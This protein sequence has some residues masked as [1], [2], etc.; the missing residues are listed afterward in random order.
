MSTPFI[1]KK[2]KYNIPLTRTLSRDDYCKIYPNAIQ[3]N[4]NNEI[5]VITGSNI[6]IVDLKLLFA[7]DPLRPPSPEDTLDLDLSTFYCV[8]N[9]H[10][11]T[12]DEKTNNNDNDNNTCLNFNL[13]PTIS[14]PTFKNARWCHRPPSWFMYHGILAAIQSNYIVTLYTRLLDDAQ[15]RHFRLTHSKISHPNCISWFDEPFYSDNNRNIQYIMIG[16]T[17][18][19]CILL[20]LT[21]KYDQISCIDVD[22]VSE[23]TCL[24]NASD[25]AITAINTIKFYGQ[26]FVAVGIYSGCVQIWINND[27][28][29][30]DF[31]RV[32]VID[33]KS[34]GGISCMKWFRAFDNKSNGIY[35]CIA[36]CRQIIILYISRHYSSFDW[37][38]DKTASYYPRMAI[39]AIDF[40]H[41]EDKYIILSSSYDGNIYAWLLPKGNP[42][43]KFTEQMKQVIGNDLYNKL[44]NDVYDKLII[45]EINNNTEMKDDK[46]I[47]GSLGIQCDP[48]CLLVS[49]I[50][51]EDSKIN[52]HIYPVSMNNQIIHDLLLQHHFLSRTYLQPISVTLV[53]RCLQTY[54]VEMMEQFIQYYKSQFKKWFESSDKLEIN[55]ILNHENDLRYSLLMIRY[56]FSMIANPPKWFRNH[57]QYII[58][59]LLQIHCWK[60][61]HQFVCSHNNQNVDSE[62]DYI[63]IYLM[64]Y[65]NVTPHLK[66]EDNQVTPVFNYLHQQILEKLTSIFSLLKDNNCTQKCI[67]L[68][69]NLFADEDNESNNEQNCTIN[70]K[71]MDRCPQCN[72]VTTVSMHNGYCGSQRDQHLIWRCTVTFKIIIDDNQLHCSLCEG[73]N[74]DNDID[75]MTHY[76]NHCLPF[77]CPICIIP[78]TKFI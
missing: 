74:N 15:W 4:T 63:C 5:A 53:M 1:M 57:I 10:Q 66:Q 44:N 17:H 28:D 60:T 41:I 51:H 42:I 70:F 25:V 35:C 47:Y 9:T 29:L 73:D 38:N 78:L 14:T 67:F 36:A 50:T 21:F 54:Y 26:Y 27:E 16:T 37:M 20:K 39:S 2:H 64:F 6:D 69:D 48:N 11:S 49:C 32:R 18:A 46:I 58:H 72:S 71:A 59:T 8:S 55:D 76:F 61:M 62:R 52:L 56:F 68:Q 24:S 7:G 19:S 34:T 23:I 13:I 65:W 3:W 33:L 30:T 75:L 45:N 40:V 31:E 22:F 77:I 12:E 43:I